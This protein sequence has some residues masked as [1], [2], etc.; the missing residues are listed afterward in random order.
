[1]GSSDVALE[2]FC[3]TESVHVMIVVVLE[4]TM[5]AYEM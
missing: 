3:P 1:M 4:K 2:I 5:S